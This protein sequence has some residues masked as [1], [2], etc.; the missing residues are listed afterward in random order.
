MDQTVFIAHCMAIA[1]SHFLNTPYK[2]ISVRDLYT[3]DGF[4]NKASGICHYCTVD[5]LDEILKNNSLR[6][7]D[8]RFLNDTTEFLEVIPLIRVV[9]QNVNYSPA[10]K[11]FILNSDVIHELEEYKQSYAGISH[12]TG[13][14]QQ[15][16]YRTYTCSLSTNNDSLDMWNYYALTHSGVSVCFDFAWNMFEGS[17]KS[18]INTGDRLD[19]DIIIYRGLVLYGNEEKKKCIAELLNRLQTIFDDA[20]ENVEKYSNYIL[21]AF[22]ES[23][24]HMRCFFKNENFSN[25]QEY[26][27][28]LK[29]PENLLRPQKDNNPIMKTGFFKRGNVLIPYID[30]SFRKESI[31]RVTINPYVKENNSIFELGIK[32]L[33]WMKGMEDVKVVRSHIPIRKYD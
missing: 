32:E 18:E 33:L 10:F 31:K 29:V 23:V 27:V 13:D 21:Y 11:D 1:R 9:L 2:E 26:R 20:Q 22:K 15:M 6:F 8:V 14:Y 16:M 7:T 17:D 30:Y 5:T 12:I 25:E 28:V 3:I 4:A 24:N 19:N